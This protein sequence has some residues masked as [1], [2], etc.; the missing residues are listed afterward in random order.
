[1]VRAQVG[2]LNPE[3]KDRGERPKILSGATRRANTS[4]REM[5]IEDAR[6]LHEKGAL[7]LDRNGFILVKHRT[8][9]QDFRDTQ[10]VRQ[11]YFPEMAEL[12][13]RVVGADEVFT[14]SY[15]QLRS[16]DPENF[17]NAY[18]LYVHCDYADRLSDHLTRGLL[19]EQ[20]SPLANDA[21]GWRF[22]WYNLWRPIEREVQKRP[23]TIMDASTLD[24]AD[25]VE[26]H[27][28]EGGEDMVASL[29]VYNEKQRLYYF[30]RMQTD[31]LL[32]FKQLD[33]DPGRSQV[34]PHTS[35]DDPDATPDALERRSIELR[36][37]CAFAPGDRA[38]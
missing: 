29:P 15:Y 34:C 12:L 4:P 31:E 37:M 11:K 33:S 32:L 35:F 6:P 19:R 16:E 7:D 38:G 14:H 26:Y 3:W 20:D 30:P 21:E 1:M 25:V 24:P 28:A 18:S 22:A 27:P 17:L 23:L 2:Y 5:E 8:S 13:R 10:E 36:M 9:V